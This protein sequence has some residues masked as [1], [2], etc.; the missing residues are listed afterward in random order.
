MPKISV[1]M[2]EIKAFTTLNAKIYSIYRRLDQLSI[3]V[4]YFVMQVCE[5]C[6]G[7]HVTSESQVSNP[8]ATLSV[9]QAHLFQIPINNK[10]IRTPII[11]IQGGEI[12]QISDGAIIKIM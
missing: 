2:H 1:G 4:V 10:T 5:L 11:R 9:E 3:N 6:A 7:Q 12:T 8:F